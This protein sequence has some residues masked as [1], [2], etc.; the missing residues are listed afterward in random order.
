MFYPIH[1]TFSKT[2]Q[3]FNKL[4]IQ[5]EDFSLRTGSANSFELDQGLNN[6]I[7]EDVHILLIK[8]ILNH[9]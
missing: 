4:K 7:A 8:I 6:F 5:K 3:E 2:Q 9:T 1:N